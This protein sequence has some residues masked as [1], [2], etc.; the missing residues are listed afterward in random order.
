MKI[1]FD[2]RFNRLYKKRSHSE[3][4]NMDVA[5]Q[6]LAKFFLENQRPT[7]LGVRNLRKKVWELRVGLKLRIIFSLEVDAVHILYLGSHD[8]IR[9]FLKNL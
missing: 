2:S 8:E 3:Q 1:L 9:K 5:L 6:R 4:E 7:G